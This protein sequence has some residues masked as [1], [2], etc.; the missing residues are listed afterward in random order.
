M[1]TEFSIR[2]P[3]GWRKVGRNHAPLVVAELSGN[4][5]QSYSRAV[6]LV[7]AAIDAGVEAIKL[8]TY[9]PDTMT[10]DCDRDYFRVEVNDAWAGQTLYSLYQ[11]AQTPWEWHPQLKEI[12]ESKGV[13][14][15]SSPFDATAVDFLEGLDVQLYK[16]AS[17]EIVDIQLLQKVGS[18]RKP[19]IVSRGMASESDIERAISTLTDAGAPAIAVLHCVS[20]YPA[21]PKQMNLATV[22]DL[23]RRFDVV[24]G[25]S[26]HSLGTSVAVASVAL[27]ASIIEK[28][29]T[30][31]RSDGGPDAAFSLEPDELRSLI[32]QIRV[33]HE[34]IGTPSYSPDE[35]ER[36]NM[37]FRRFIFVTKDIRAGEKF[38]DNNLRIIRPGYGL[39]PRFLEH[40]IGKTAKHDIARG[41]PLSI[42]LIN[43]ASEDEFT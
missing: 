10:I 3:R 30:L 22:P 38:D 4:H 31:R 42:D 15:F 11:I 37:V 23:A 21:Q 12:C 18:T 29:V 28:H 33:A 16:I 13:L 7:N 43:N 39:E 34:A 14:M 24:S 5:N 25:L 2:T 19:V 9:T 8:Q 6:E 41:T 27:G 40:V 36:A 35:D 17:F 32:E 1:P 20:S 26:D